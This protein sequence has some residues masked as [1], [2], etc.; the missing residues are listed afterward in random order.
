MFNLL[1]YSAEEVRFSQNKERTSE[2]PKKL[3]TK[4]SDCCRAGLSV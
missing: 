4:S 3:V 1:V 2:D